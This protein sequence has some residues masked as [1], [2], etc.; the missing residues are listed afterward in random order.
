LAFYDT[1]QAN[2]RINSSLHGNRKPRANPKMDR[3]HDSHGLGQRH[4]P[5]S[6]IQKTESAAE[7]MAALKARVSAAIGSSKAK[8][9]LNVGLHPVLE[10]LA[11][12]KPSTGKAG[13]AMSGSSSRFQS[14]S[15]KLSGRPGYGAYGGRATDGAK[16]TNPYLEDTSSAPGHGGK[17]RQP[18]Q[19]VFNQKGKYIQQAN[20]LRRQAALEAMKRRI[21]EQTRKAG[22][23]EDLDME[24]NFVVDAPPAVE[25][26]DE[27]LVNGDY[28]KIEDP[29]A[30]K[31]TTPDSIIT[32]YVQHPVAI[33]PPQDKNLPPPKPM[34]L[35]A[36][37][38]AKLRRQRRMA[39]LKEQ[40]DKIRL[41]L[42]PAPPPKVKKGN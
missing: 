39:N 42:E 6:R 15:A 1:F 19:L 21:A 24:K 5:T 36:K 26:W 29:Q 3:P 23:D 33:E 7:K 17:E 41:G 35:T 9:G 8:G 16:K 10:D 31:L 32:E 40:Q 22:I 2:L 27:A 34:F 12:W 4:D 38:Q 13:D 14:D 30:L 28:S 20:A 18:R 11:T 25:W 37:E